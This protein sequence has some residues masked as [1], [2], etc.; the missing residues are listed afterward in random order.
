MR[1]SSRRNVT[2]KGRAKRRVDLMREDKTTQFEVHASGGE[3]PSE[4]TLVVN[5][6]GKDHTGENRIATVEFNE[7]ETATIIRVIA[8]SKRAREAMLNAVFDT[9][10]TGY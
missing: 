9:D 5:V 7:D 2:M 1:I 3:K 4:V 10:A 6:V 8:M